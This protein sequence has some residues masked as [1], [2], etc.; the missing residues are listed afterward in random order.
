MKDFLRR[1]WHKVSGKKKQPAYHEI[2]G[3]DDEAII[4]FKSQA[5]Q[6][7]E[8]VDG[9]S[10]A[11]DF[12]F[13]SH[14]TLKLFMHYLRPEYTVLDV[15]AGTGRL[16][17]PVADMGCHVTA[18][19]ISAEMLAEIEKNKG[20]RAVE[21]AKAS[22]ESL[23]FADETFD[24]V[25]QADFLIHFPNWRTLLTEQLRVCKP[26]A[27][28]VFTMV[29]ADNLR[30]FEGGR[31]AGIAYLSGG[32]YYAS[33]TREE[34]ELFA[35]ENGAE[36]VRIHPYRLFTNSYAESLLTQ[37]EHAE[38]NRLVGKACQDQ[39]IMAAV[40][41]LEL[42]IVS[43]LPEDATAMAVMAIRKLPI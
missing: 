28:I 43:E 15:G 8:F 27:P 39:R 37:K 6:G 30:T 24:A 34:L 2:M 18:T 41:R 13:F 38:L 11:V 40:S 19:D 16:T 20:S 26:G 3:L 22:A 21:T 42:E 32:G 9:Y 5:W 23:P 35:S 14:V 33:C 10:K 4:A 36:V 25:V 12:H 1:M 31:V 17:F 29:N 7:K